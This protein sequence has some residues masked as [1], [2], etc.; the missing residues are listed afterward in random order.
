MRWTHNDSLA[1]RDV[2]DAG[3]KLRGLYEQ[4]QAGLAGDAAAKQQTQNIYGPASLDDQFGAAVSA[5]DQTARDQVEFGLTPEEIASGKYNQEAATQNVTGRRYGL[6]D[7]PTSWQDKQF[8]QQQMD[9]AR[10]KGMADYYLKNGDY[11]K[12]YGLAHMA[13]QNQLT[14][15]QI[16]M[17]PEQQ[18]ALALGNT[19][20]QGQIDL[21]PGQKEL[22]GLNVDKIKEEL[23]RDKMLAT[24]G[25]HSFSGNYQGIA[26]LVSKA[27]PELN[28]ATADVNPKTKAIEFKDA[29]GTVLRSF[30]DATEMGA[31]AHASID[32]SKAYQY[33]RD[34]S[35]DKKND[36]N[37]QYLMKKLDND[38]LRYANHFAPQL[39]TDEK[40]G[41]IFD[42]NT[43]SFFDTKGNKITDD[44]R[45]TKLMKLSS[46][47][48]KPA[49]PMSVSDMSQLNEMVGA[50]ISRDPQLKTMAKEDYDSAY[51]IAKG[52]VLGRANGQ[53]V[54]GLK[55][56]APTPGGDSTEG[57]KSPPA[58][59]P[60]VRT[61]GSTSA[62]DSQATNARLIPRG[63]PYWGT[64]V[65]GN[66]MQMQEYINVGTGEISK[67]PAGAGLGSLST[68]GDLK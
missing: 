13:M 28:I 59:K 29:N 47:A 37:F 31:F 26:D 16:D 19:H 46:T 48:G 25:M 40:G 36:Q 68:F 27:H 23:A 14:Q 5:S 62:P 9:T 38:S 60:V 34:I 17:L 20:L 39:I 63:T 2:T 57:R 43:K 7:A 41:V 65:S 10:M 24:I 52:R 64:D 54:K 61:G 12:G 50:E 6:G 51:D 66:L 56:G 44:D 33:Y 3:E 1:Y 11:M 18:R 58:P 4:Y 53:S 8:T 32:P 45:L 15:G 21:Q 67:R 30:K 35:T 42:P 55:D 22:Q 49:P